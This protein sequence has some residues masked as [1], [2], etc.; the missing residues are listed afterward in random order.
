MLPLAL[1]T[2]GLKI[3]IPSTVVSPRPPSCT[4][5]AESNGDDDDDGASAAVENG[6][7]VANDVDVDELNVDELN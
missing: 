1:A 5:P 6:T 4:P 2:P 3:T 7:I